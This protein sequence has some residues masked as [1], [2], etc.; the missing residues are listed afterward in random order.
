[1]KKMTF[2]SLVISSFLLLGNFASA[3][4]SIT[5]CGDSTV[6]TYSSGVKQGWG[7]RLSGFTA[8][9]VKIT[10]LAAGGRSTK[11]FI[12]E[13]RWAN[14]LATKAKYIFIQFGHND[15]S[16]NESDANTTFKSNLQKMV[17]DAKMQKSIPV[18]ITPTRRLK[19]NDSKHMSTDLGPYANAMNE[20]AAKNNIPLIDLYAA[21]A[22]AYIKMGEKEALKGFVP[23]DRTHTTSK[24]ATLLAK[25]V[26]DEAKRNSK[27]RALFK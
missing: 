27:L 11:T 21:S 16:K 26:A 12:S 1:M 14:A 9:G 17:N 4:D 23:G 25:I 8:A 18:L 3:A 19:F 20:V 6:A 7:A 5:I 2:Y 24:G 10:N 15:Q 22:R 13:G